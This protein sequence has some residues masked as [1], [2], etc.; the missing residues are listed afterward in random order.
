MIMSRCAE[1]TALRAR[2]A[3]QQGQPQ[4]PEGSIGKLAG[5][6]IARQAAV[7]H[8]MTNESECMLTESD[9]PLDGVI[10]EVL[11]SVPAIS[12]A[13]GTDEIQKNIIS[14]RVLGMQKEPRMDTGPFRDVR[15]N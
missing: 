4:G 2:S 6:N 1:W 12:I 13:G 10:S 5:S 8:T 3:Q 15:K 14:E 11:I 9:A 7:V